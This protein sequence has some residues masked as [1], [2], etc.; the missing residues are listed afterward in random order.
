VGAPDNT[1]EAT[2]KDQYATRHNPFVYFHSIIDDRQRCDAHVVNLSA[3]EADL[4]DAARTPNYA[5][6][7]PDLCSDGH[8]ATC[9]NPEQKGGYE[10]IDAF[11][12]KWVPKILAS[13]A[14]RQDGLLIVTFDEAEDDA[15]ACC[16]EPTGPNTARP[17]IDGP[18]GGRVGAV[19]L[20]PLI[21]P[22]TT[23]DTPINHYGYLRSVEDIFG[24]DHLGA[25]GQD[26]LATFQSAGIFNRP[27]GG[28][29]APVAKAVRRFRVTRGRG[30]RRL[31]VRFSLAPGVV[32][33]LAFK[34]RGKVRRRLTTGG[35]GTL[36]LR[37]RARRRYAV[38][39]RAERD[40]RVVARRRR[41]SRPR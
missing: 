20:S 36:R 13:P 18:G 31:V 35:R 8:D 41:V 12:R 10:G 7:V 40:G 25:A 30:G 11:L 37:V 15:S 21:E 2:A 6:I 3:L 9:A 39:L 17:G 32:G 14:F 24:L 26:G 38:V 19:L 5:F 23:S 34:R 33:R 1:Q 27:G 28:T 22:G 4:A 29:T 16:D